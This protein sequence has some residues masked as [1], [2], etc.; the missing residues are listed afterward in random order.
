MR[1]I[2]KKTKIKVEFYRNIS[3]IDMIIAII[4][5]GIEVLLFQ[6]NFGFFQYVI[7]TFVF[8]IFVCLFIPLDGEKLYMQI[9]HWV[10][11]LISGKS[12]K[13]NSHDPKTDVSSIIPYK[14]IKDGLIEY[15]DYYGGVIEIRPKEFRLLSEYKQSELIDK[16]LGSVIRSVSGNSSASIV[17]VDRPVL[18]DG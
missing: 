9:A 15:G 14:G 17:K 3:I 12:Y 10:S 2:P 6:A 5:I 18:L 4:G 8:G 11:F 7:M 13:K 16:V 1:I